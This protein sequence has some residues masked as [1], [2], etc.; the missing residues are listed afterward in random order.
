M[1]L[2]LSFVIDE[3]M[4]YNFFNLFLKVYFIY[5][6]QILTTYDTQLVHHLAKISSVYLHFFSNRN[7]FR[8]KVHFLS[9]FITGVKGTESF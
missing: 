4:A 5:R 1:I 7:Y 2:S 6:L 3:N 8:K 9:S